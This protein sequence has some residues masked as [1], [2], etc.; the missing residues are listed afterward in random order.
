V[1]QVKAKR[2]L[3]REQKREFVAAYHEKVASAKFGVLLGYGGLK[4]HA[5]EELRRQLR[6]YKGE[7]KVVKNRLLKIAAKGTTAEN[8]KDSVEGAP[9][10]VILAFGDPVPVAKIVAKFAANNEALVLVAGFLGEKVL[11]GAQ[12]RTLSTLPSREVLMSQLLGLFKSPQQQMVSLLSSIVRNFV[13]L[14]SGYA[15]KKQKAA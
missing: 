6:D 4:Y 3:N 15:D 13:Y 5:I 8:W 11:T 14:L 10:A 12:V 9:R 2:R 7:F 1:A